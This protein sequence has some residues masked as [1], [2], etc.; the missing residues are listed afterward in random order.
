MATLTCSIVAA[1]PQS[2][3][4]NGSRTRARCKDIGEGGLESFTTVVLDSLHYESHLMC[5]NCGPLGLK[6]DVEPSTN[7]AALSDRSWAHI[8]ALRRRGPR[9]AERRLRR[10][11]S[12][13][14]TCKAQ[15]N[16]LRVCSCLVGLR[17][18]LH[19]AHPAVPAQP[20][21]RQLLC[22]EWYEHPVARVQP[23][24]PVEAQEDQA[25]HDARALRGRERRLR[26]VWAARV[27]AST[28][29]TCCPTRT[30]TSRPF[31]S[32]SWSTWCAACSAAS[33]TRSSS[34]RGRTRSTTRPPRRRT[35][36]R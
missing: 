19:Q 16:K 32:S 31:A 27:G 23:A 13:R 1:C 28:S 33:T 15:I 5:T 2:R 7:R 17:A 9:G 22:N 11:R 26:E 6:A 12:L 36:S 21:L 14:T 35:S 18:H 25:A 4:S 3:W 24:A 20:H 10:A 30:A 8:V 34:P 29:P